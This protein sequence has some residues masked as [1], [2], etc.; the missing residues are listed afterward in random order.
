M[1]IVKSASTPAAFSRAAPPL[2]CPSCRQPGSNSSSTPRL[3]GCSTWTCRRRCSPAPTRSSNEKARLIIIADRKG[4]QTEQ[5]GG[6]D[7][8]LHK[9]HKRHH[10]SHHCCRAR[11]RD[12]H[13]FFTGPDPRRA[14]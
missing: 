3:P 5:R 14:L 9:G 6:S 1:L 13:V 7:Y 4:H 11:L 2:T 8:P 10:K 12:L